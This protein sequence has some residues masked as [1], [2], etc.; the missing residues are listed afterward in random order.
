MTDANRNIDP[1]SDAAGRHAPP[2]AILHAALTPHRSLNR[3]GHMALMLV[4][5][6]VC[7]GQGVMF[8]AIGAWPVFGFLG[9]D[10]LLVWYAFRRSYAQAR[11]FEE[12][13]VSAEEVV[14]RKVSAR[15]V[16]QIY[17]FNPVWVRLDVTRIADEGVT[18]LALVSHGKSVILGAFLNP[19]DRE[20]FSRALAAALAAARTG[21]PLNA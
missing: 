3:S 15:G 8:M 6:A 11:E 4:V 7:F 19:P 20:S 10:V 13:V 18:A 9:L 14:L 21:R 17:R 16:E 2:A 5:G 1:V 12:V